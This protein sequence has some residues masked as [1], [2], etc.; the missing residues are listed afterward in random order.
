MRMPFILLFSVV[1]ICILSC[2]DILSKR[3]KITDN[4]YLLENEVGDMSVWFKSSQ[5]DFVRRIPE[6][7]LEYGVN[8]SFIIAKGVIDSEMRVY[9]INRKNDSHFAEPKDYLSGPFSLSQF[10]SISRLRKWHVRF[11]KT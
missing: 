9:L 1:V 6:K 7:V 11:T 3:E 4:Y 8:D 10:D 2:G 5:G